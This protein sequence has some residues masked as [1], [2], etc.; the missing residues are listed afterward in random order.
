MVA[1]IEGS[2]T[3]S[4]K[5]HAKVGLRGGTVRQVGTGSAAG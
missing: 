2:N 3:A 4:L 5:L 1:A